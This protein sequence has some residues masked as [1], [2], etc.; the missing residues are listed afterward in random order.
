MYLKDEKQDKKCAKC[1][2]IFTGNIKKCKSAHNGAG[3]YLIKKEL[4]SVLSF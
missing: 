1:L 3:G 2:L 4:K